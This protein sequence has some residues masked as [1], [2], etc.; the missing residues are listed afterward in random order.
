MDTL[1]LLY[2]SHKI[3]KLL[4]R[5]LEEG[6]AALADRSPRLRSAVW[7][8]EFDIRVD[9]RYQQDSPEVVCVQIWDG[10]KIWPPRGNRQPIWGPAL[11]DEIERMVKCQHG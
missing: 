7:S 1:D 10:P 9:Y 2:Q 11:L 8:F 4:R 3:D 5:K 6:Y